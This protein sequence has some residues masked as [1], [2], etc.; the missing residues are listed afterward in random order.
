MDETNNDELKELLEE[1]IKISRDNNEILTK[2]YRSYQRGRLVKIIY[3]SFIILVTFGAYYLIQPYIE[4]LGQAY[5]G[6]KT[7]VE[8][9]HTIGESIKSVF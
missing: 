9:I 4:M 6:I 5:G 3:W 1:N 7:Q 2:L 8:G